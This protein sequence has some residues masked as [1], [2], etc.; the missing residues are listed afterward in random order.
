MSRKATADP[1]KLA[2]NW[3]AQEITFLP[4]AELLPHARNARTHSDDQILQIAAS[5][6]EF[7]WTNPVL[8]DENRTLIAGHGRVLAAPHLNWTEAPC[9]IARGWSESKKRAYMIADNK[10]ALNASWDIEMLDAELKALHVESFS[11]D[12]L[13]FSDADLARLDDDLAQLRFET[14]GATEATEG[15]EENEESSTRLGSDQV[16]LSLPMTV[17]ERALVFEAI[18]AAKIQ[19]G[20]E[21]GG[22]A[23]CQI[24]RHYLNRA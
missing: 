10:L 19:Y 14:A 21:Q 1:I 18:T 17:A 13:G 7:G 4:L 6:R 22:P 12:L 24:C 23:L 20:M 5:M 9:M 16:N 15:N 3:P 8:I 2:A 11:S